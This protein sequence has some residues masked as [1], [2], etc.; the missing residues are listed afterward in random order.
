MAKKVFPL[1]LDTKE[2]RIL[3]ALSE[4]D[5]CSMAEAARRIIRSYKLD[6]VSAAAT[7]PTAEM[8]LATTDSH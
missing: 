7:L 3:E 1:S 4:R 6:V 8:T 5:G 2:R